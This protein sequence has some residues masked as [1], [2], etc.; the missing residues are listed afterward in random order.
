MN[1]LKISLL[2]SLI[3][4][5]IYPMSVSGIMS[6]WSVD[7]ISA[8]N[9]GG[10]LKIVNGQVFCDKCTGVVTMTKGVLKRIIECKQGNCVE[11]QYNTWTGQ[12]ILPQDSAQVNFKNPILAIISAHPL[13]SKIIAGSLAI[14]AGYMAYKLSQPAKKLKQV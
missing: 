12:Q 1:F 8:S 4:T 7:S 14:A 13:A 11:T 6:G 10:G 9:T 5:P 2:M 3:A